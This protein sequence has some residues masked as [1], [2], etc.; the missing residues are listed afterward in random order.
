MKY[1]Y[2]GKSYNRPDAISK[3]TGKAVYLDDIRLPGML[4]CRSVYCS[5]FHDS[6][7]DYMSRKNQKT[8]YCYYYCYYC[9]YSCYCC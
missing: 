5:D 6:A 2:L 8:D 1:K 7:D 3:V 4:Y 9:Y